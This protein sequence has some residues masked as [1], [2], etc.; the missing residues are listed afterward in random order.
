[1][2]DA[3]P[4][5]PPPRA[6]SF[7]TGSTVS[8]VMLSP[9]AAAGLD[10]PPTSTRNFSTLREQQQHALE[11]RAERLHV[12]AALGALQ[13]TLADIG[14]QE[15]EAA[16]A[17]ASWPVA[18]GDC[19]AVA[20]DPLH[21]RLV[22]HAKDFGWPEPYDYQLHGAVSVLRGT[23]TAVVWP[24]GGGKGLMATLAAAASPG[25]VVLLIA[26][27]LALAA[28]LADSI[29]DAWG[30][31][32]VHDDN[33]ERAIAYMLG[34]TSEDDF[35]DRL[36]KPCDDLEARRA[37]TLPPIPGAKPADPS[38]RERLAPGKM[39]SRL[40]KQLQLA[41]KDGRADAPLVLV[42][43]PEKLSLSLQL[44]AFLRAAHDLDLLGPCVVDEFH[45]L[46]EH[47]YDFRPLYLVLGLFVQSLDLVVLLFTATAPPALVTAASTILRLNILPHV[48]RCPTG[49]L[50]A[51]MT[52]QVLP[53]ASSAQRRQVLAA[54]LHK[55]QGDCVI[56]YCAT[57]STCEELAKWYSA[58]GSGE[59]GVGGV[60][61][62]H[63]KIALGT[64]EDHRNRWSLGTLHVMFCTIAW[65]MG[66]DKSN[67]RA[68]IHWG[69]PKSVASF[70]QEASRA[71]RDGQH[72]DSYLLYDLSGWAAS[73]QQRISKC[74]SALS[75]EY[76]LC[77]SL[78][79][80]RFLIDGSV[81]RHRLLE[82][83][84][85]D[86]SAD[87][88]CTCVAAGIEP[89][90]RC[91]SCLAVPSTV[92][93]AP[94]VQR[95]E[96]LPALIECATALQRKAAR[97]PLLS[98]LVRAWRRDKPL[99]WAAWQ[100]DY[101]L[102]WALVSGVFSLIPTLVSL[103]GATNMTEMRDLWVIGFAVSSSGLHLA[104]I[105]P[106]LDKIPLPPAFD[107]KR[108]RAAF[109]VSIEV[110]AGSGALPA[111]A[112]D[113][114]DV[115]RAF[116][117]AVEGASMEDDDASLLAR[118][119]ECAGREDGGDVPTDNTSPEAIFEALRGGVPGE[120]SCEE[121]DNEESN[122]GGSDSSIE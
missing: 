90:R 105:S 27:L 104:E 63:S 93:A 35:H 3:T 87:S 116:L 39:L 55:H 57:T 75:R 71:G 22:K 94:I 118:L 33:S 117:D 84:L 42:L 113:E 13:Q 23:H 10:T 74:P 29:N 68:V 51:N 121:S 96:W 11:L 12:Q 9:A 21:P 31:E 92:P 43:S 7:H 66:M 44:H 49:S 119:S 67:V 81:C 73:A 64:K 72:A 106:D 122:D 77:Q 34:G 28:Q 20:L 52:Y 91:A 37:A 101:A 80:L 38:L 86:G 103:T 4:R 109:G 120:S 82:R 40:L 50:R 115:F 95:H 58:V 85:G 59:G 48:I 17:I 65:G 114:S 47:G 61:F 6:R 53:I 18:I 2:S 5:V 26:P 69:L 88:R 78:A 19:D 76:G 54:L 83:A 100:C 25:K 14:M 16:D 111:E 112:E 108:T 30:S 15:T 56:V 110:S 62:F 70:Y 79:L 102:A 36:I 32:H 107:P 1:M 24:A 45:C 60:A 41:P 46:A 89:P 97:T 98:Q 99:Q 8:T